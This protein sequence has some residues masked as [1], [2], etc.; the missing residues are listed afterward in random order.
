MVIYWKDDDNNNKGYCEFDISINSKEN[1]INLI[2]NE[3]FYKYALK[4]GNRKF[5]INFQEDIKYDKFSIDIMVYNG[6]VE[7][8]FLYFAYEQYFY[9][10][11]IP[12][13]LVID[14]KDL[15][16][17]KIEFQASYNSFFIIKYN[18]ISNSLNQ[19]NNNILSDESQLIQINLTSK[20]N[21]NTINFI[22][23]KARLKV[24]IFS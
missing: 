23:Y 24:G 5:K 3:T 19:L 10:N 1:G 17:Y 9:P 7:F 4:D 8:N 18:I 15:Y 2:E 13:N 12:Y 6:N 21:Y 20:T 16:L 11:Q 14:E 22:R